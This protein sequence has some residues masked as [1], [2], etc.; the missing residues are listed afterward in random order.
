MLYLARLCRRA[1]TVS[2]CV[3]PVHTIGDVLSNSHVCVHVVCACSCLVLHISVRCVDRVE[4]CI[5][6]TCQIYDVDIGIYAMM[7]ACTFAQ[8]YMTPALPN[9]SALIYLY[10]ACASQC[11]VCT[12][13]PMHLARNAFTTQVPPLSRC[14]QQHT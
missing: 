9:N 14:T 6:H 1:I 3:V 11:A 10:R 13:L 2:T 8:W 7:H 5:F 4:A 12:A